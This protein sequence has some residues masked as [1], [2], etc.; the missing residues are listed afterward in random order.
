MT[1]AR[2]AGV[3][4]FVAPLKDGFDTWIGYHGMRF[5]GGQRQRLGLARALL[6]NPEFLILDEATSAIDLV[7]E[8][9]VRKTIEAQ[10]TGRT[11]LIITHRLET[12]REVDHVIWI[13]GGQ[14]RAS[15]KPAELTGVFNPEYWS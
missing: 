1:A 9:R 3:D 14:M 4:E 8:S 2:Q 13:E 6:R 11:I 10:L 12:I 15:G 7:N 5:S